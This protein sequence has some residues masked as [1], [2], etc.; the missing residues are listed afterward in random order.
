[1]DPISFT[2]ASHCISITTNAPGTK[3]DKMLQGRKMEQESFLLAL[4]F[5]VIIL[6]TK[7]RAALPGHRTNAAGGGPSSSHLSLD[8][9]F[10]ERGLCLRLVH[11]YKD[12]EDNEAARFC[13]Y[14]MTTHRRARIWGLSGGVFAEHM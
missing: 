7:M 11:L 14:C 9:R 1:M 10:P 6:S 4:A 2:D 8:V 12:V 13:S 3:C 5:S